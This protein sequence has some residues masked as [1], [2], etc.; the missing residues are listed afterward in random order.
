M[1]TK[2]LPV[3]PESIAEAGEIIRN[4]G[5]VGFP[6]ETVYGLGANALD[7]NAVRAIFEAKGRPGDNPL[8]THV[9]TEAEIPPLI[10]GHIPAA[11]DQRLLQLLHP[12]LLHTA[13]TRGNA[14]AVP[15]AKQQEEL[16][17][18]DAVTNSLFMRSS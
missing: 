4:G 3:T 2:L 16:T 13:G 14:C 1:N 6:T 9:A 12:H 11:A 8:I 7:G 15:V 17:S 5:L 18:S 10:H